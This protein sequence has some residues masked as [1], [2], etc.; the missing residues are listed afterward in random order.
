MIYQQFLLFKEAVYGQED[1]WKVWCLQVLGK[2]VY[3]ILMYNRIKTHFTIQTLQQF[4]RKCFFLCSGCT[5]VHSLRLLLIVPPSNFPHLLLS[6]FINFLPRGLL[7]SH[8]QPVLQ[9]SLYQKHG[10]NFVF[11]DY[12]QYFLIYGLIRGKTHNPLGKKFHF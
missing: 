2:W 3:H 8:S 10:E 7:I 6:I 5:P 1:I 11:Y 12:R 9:S 4:S